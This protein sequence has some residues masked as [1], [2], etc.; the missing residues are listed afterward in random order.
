[1]NKRQRKK[2]I[3]Q[4]STRKQQLKFYKQEYTIMC[5]EVG[6]LEFKAFVLSEENK[7]LKRNEAD[8]LKEINALKTPWYKRLGRDSK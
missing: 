2:A 5:K 1:M 7:K 3:A 8:L 4:K 6:E